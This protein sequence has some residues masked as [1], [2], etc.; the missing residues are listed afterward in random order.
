[1]KK[2]GI[3][4]E[5]NLKNA[6]YGNRLQA[7]A[8]NKY[9]NTN[10]NCKAESITLKGIYDVNEKTKKYHFNFIKKIKKIPSK[11]KFKLN[12]GKYNFTERIEACNNFTKNNTN[13]TPE[14]MTF[15]MIQNSDYDIFITGSDVVWAQVKGAVHRIRFLDFKTQKSFEKLAYAPS[16]GRDWIPE[17]NVDT[18]RKFLSTFKAISVREKSS[19]KMLRNIGIENVQHVCDP[20]LLFDKEEWQKIEKAVDIKEKYIFVYL[21]GKNEKQRKKIED[22]AKKL[23]LKIVSVPHANEVYDSM[24]DDFGDYRVDNCSP[25][26]WI[27]LIHNAEYVIID[28]FHGAVFA[29][30]FEKKFLVAK[31]YYV[32]NINNRMIDYLDTIGESDKLLDVS[33][34]STLD[35]MEWDYDKINK[36]LS[37]F[38]SH[39]KDYLNKNIGIQNV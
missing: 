8:L 12:K 2:I 14:P 22:L 25:E 3:I 24:D 37:K 38:I 6:N 10:Y 19:I 21:L 36:N 29:T 9:L 32:E 31:R 4:S 11:I 17:E 1:M 30:I 34:L 35:N 27:W 23:N 26:E 13:L 33:D 20:T 16:F 18:I 15:E 7:Y 39:S 28:S 5:L